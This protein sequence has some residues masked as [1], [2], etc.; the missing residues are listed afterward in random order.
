[1]PLRRFARFASAQRRPLASRGVRT[2]NDVDVSTRPTRSLVESLRLRPLLWMERRRPGGGTRI[3]RPVHWGVALPTETALT[4]W[5]ARLVDELEAMDQRAIAV[6][7]GL[8]PDQLNWRAAKDTWSI[9]QCLQH[10]HVA[11]EVYLPPIAAA[12]ER[13]PHSPVHDINPGW[14]GRWFIRNYIEPSSGGRR[15]RAPGK[16]APGER[17]DQSIVDLFLRSNQA[18]RDLVRRAS[19]YDVNRIRFRN[20]FIPLVRFTVGTGLEI[21]SKHERRHL[22]QAARVRQD[23]NFGLDL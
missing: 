9:G 8:D 5:S 14:V 3:G 4:A 18:A 19:A 15:A 10:L 16:I 23:L 22:L 1:M 6:T 17:V 13:Q 12:L 11:N 21:V 2:R 7:R 20:P